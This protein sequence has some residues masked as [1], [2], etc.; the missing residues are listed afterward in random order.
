[1]IGFLATGDE[2]I[3]GNTLNTNSKLIAEILHSEGFSIGNHLMSGDSEEDMI[4]CIEFLQKKHKA[5][6]ITGGLGPTSD[7]RTRYALSQVTRETLIPFDAALK[8]IESRLSHANL[9]MTDG[10][11]QQC[12]FPKN[13]T[14]F[15][16]PYGTAFGCHVKTTEH[17]YYLLPGP[18]RECVPM[19]THWALPILSEEAKTGLVQLK[20]RLFG[21]AEGDIANRLDEAVK[22]IPCRTG[23]RLDIPYTECKV[24]CAPEDVNLVTNTLKPILLPH[25][26][27]PDNQKASAVLIQL[28]K[29]KNL[30]INLH[31]SVTGGR[32]ETLLHR[33]DMHDHVYFQEPFAEDAPHF[34]C[35]GL[36]AFWHS[37][38]SKETTVTLHYEHADIKKSETKVLPFR[39]V[40]VIEMATEWLC[41]RMAH[42]LNEIH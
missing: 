3:E 41:F 7:D 2:L 23:Y 22:D 15:S 8:H 5:I 12:L 37:K 18:P 10:N 31:D 26:L 24:Y 13:A 29:A 9:P 36:E 17:D 25:Q 39:S 4:N 20:W 30:K 27:F 19:F 28:L 16:N 34:Y 14:L 42:L 33:Q 38:H 21:V 6:I 1:M 11:Y 40:L 32:L 35:E